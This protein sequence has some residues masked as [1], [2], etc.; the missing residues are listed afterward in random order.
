MSGTFSSV[1]VVLSVLLLLVSGT[2]ATPRKS[3]FG[4][5]SPRQQSAFHRRLPSRRGSRSSNEN[6]N[7]G[8]DHYDEENTD[9]DHENVDSS[10]CRCFGCDLDD[11]HEPTGANTTADF[12]KGDGNC[13]EFFT[14]LLLEFVLPCLFFGAVAGFFY[15]RRRE[16]ERIRRLRMNTQ[17][18]QTLQQQQLQSSGNQPMIFL[19]QPRNQ[20]VPQMVIQPAR[21]QQQA[22]MVPMVP[23]QQQP[24]QIIQAQ[25]A[26]L[27]PQASST[28]VPMAQAIV[29]P[30]TQVPPT[31]PVVTPTYTGR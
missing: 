8:E 15:R 6:E 19:Q 22:P 11:A 16:N 20:V 4:L 10:F 2:M 23:M 24:A 27:S 18:G 12:D 14:D 1:T 21:Q 9:E 25:G 13:G 31:Q 30:V 26:F 7:D 28:T 3:I 29:M 17:P 5:A